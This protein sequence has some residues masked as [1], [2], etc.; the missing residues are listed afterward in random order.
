MTFFVNLKFRGPLIYSRFFDHFLS[1]SAVTLSQIPQ[2]CWY[3]TTNVSRDLLTCG[4]SLIRAAAIFL[5]DM[6]PSRCKFAPPSAGKAFFPL[7]WSLVTPKKAVG[8]PR[9][10]P[11]HPTW[12]MNMLRKFQRDNLAHY[13][14]RGNTK[15]ENHSF[16]ACYGSLP[17]HVSI[18]S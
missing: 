18:I 2:L 17:G 13:W 11:K 4:R 9:F 14:D 16:W 3:C 12:C 8:P 10:A 6:D 1:F 5:A 15:L 7:F